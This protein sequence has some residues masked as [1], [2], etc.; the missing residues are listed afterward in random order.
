MAVLKEQNEFSAFLQSSNLVRFYHQNPHF[1][2][3]FGLAYM[4]VIYLMRFSL[5]FCY[6]NRVVT[7]VCDTQGPKL[8]DRQ[9]LIGN[10]NCFRTIQTSSIH[11]I[12]CISRL[13]SIQKQEQICQKSRN[14]TEGNTYGKVSFRQ[15]C[16]HVFNEDL[17]SN[18]QLL[19]R[20]L[21]YK[22]RFEVI[23]ELGN[24]RERL[25]ERC[26]I[27]LYIFLVYLHRYYMMT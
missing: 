4:M 7:F 16:Y 19:N 20:Y 2:V 12:P 8:N 24:H 9:N 10:C 13:R 21:A 15:S 25:S 18:S 23:F 17:S 26:S 22:S 5:L 3:V 6:N 27:N 11:Q 14:F 1:F